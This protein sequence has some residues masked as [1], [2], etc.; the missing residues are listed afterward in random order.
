MAYSRSPAQ[1]DVDAARLHRSV[2]TL[3]RLS[4]PRRGVRARHRCVGRRPVVVQVPDFKG[5]FWVYQV[6]DLRTDS[7][8]DLGVMYGSTPGFYLLVGPAWQGDTPKGITKVFRSTINT[9][10]VVPRVFQD[11]T[12]ADKEAVQPLIAGIDMYS[13]AKFDGM[14]KQRDWRKIPTLKS[15][16][17]DAGD[18]ETAWVFPDKFFDE[19][20]AV[21][22]DAPPRPGEETR[23]AEVRALIDAA[24][25]DPL[26]KNAI[27]DE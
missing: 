15:P 19:L 14:V 16:T 6:V 20:P 8:A 27:V 11:D 25:K 23:Y 7:F 17:G 4:Q 10:F 9:A 3:G 21:L 26:L 13:L 22:A 24:G 1:R 18:A 5:R 2:R 12:P